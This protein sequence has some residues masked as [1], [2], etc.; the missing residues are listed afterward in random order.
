LLAGAW[1]Q[2][3][4]LAVQAMRE[5][6]RLDAGPVLLDRP[7]IGAY[8]QNWVEQAGPDI[9]PPSALTGV[10]ASLVT[11]RALTNNDPLTPA[12]ARVIQETLEGLL[13]MI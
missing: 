13:G 7:E 12:D 3:A 9:F 8:F 10:R 11:L 5:Q 2:G 1:M 6:D 4:L